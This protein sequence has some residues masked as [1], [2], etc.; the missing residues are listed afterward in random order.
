MNHSYKIIPKE[1]LVRNTIVGP[2][3]FNEYRALMESVMSDKRFTSS[4]HMFWDFRNGSL[5]ELNN[6]E[7]EGIKNFI[8]RNQERRG[9]DYRVVFLV[10]E[11]VDYGLS[12]MYQII[13]QNLP[14]YFEVFYDE[15]EA[16]DWIKGPAQDSD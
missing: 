7:I 5:V 16:I 9:R 10:N 1:N 11:T 4:M 8:E 15:Q 6:E 3:T 2:L 14:V 12:R 13:S